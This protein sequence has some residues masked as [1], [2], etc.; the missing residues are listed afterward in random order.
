MLLLTAGSRKL[1]CA[2]STVVCAVTRPPGRDAF[3][4]PALELVGSTCRQRVCDTYE[5]FY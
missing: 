4:V 2:V 5:H 1:I 3:P